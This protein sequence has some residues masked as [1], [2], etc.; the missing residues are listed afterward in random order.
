MLAGAGEDMSPKVYSPAAALL[1]LCL[2]IGAYAK[3]LTPQVRAMIFAG[4]SSVSL[5]STAVTINLEGTDYHGAHKCPYMKVYINGRGPFTFLY[6][7]GSSYSIVSKRVMDAA[8]PEIVFDRSGERD[9]VRLKTVRVGGLTV[10]DLWT[11]HD[12]SFDVDGV[13]GFQAFSDLKLLFK[14]KQRKLIVSASPITLH[15]A[16]AVPYVLSHNTPTVVLQVGDTNVQTL[17]DTGD[18][19]YAFEARTEDLPGVKFAKPPIA[20]ATVKNGANLQTTSVATLAD[21]VRFGPLS[22]KDA[23]IGIN[24][25]LPVSDIG[26]DFL[27]Q[28]D[29]AFDPATRTV[30]F[31]PLVPDAEIAIRQPR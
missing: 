25:D 18:D 5:K 20:A 16:F 24:N 10:H 29:V 19:A 21:P 3:E 13:F 17:I 31:Q 6:D 12:D 11:I 28:F 4:P 7:S 22:I 8:R 30:A 23:E 27:V 14:L 26:Y 1:L 9:V 2:S 15:N